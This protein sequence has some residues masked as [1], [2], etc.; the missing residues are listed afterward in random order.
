MAKHLQFL[1][2]KYV[3]LSCILQTNVV[4]CMQCNKTYIG[5]MCLVGR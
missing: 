2:L 3:G 1:Q 5:L 4:S